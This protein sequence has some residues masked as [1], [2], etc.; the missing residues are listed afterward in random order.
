MTRRFARHFASAADPRN[1]QP[2]FGCGTDGPTTH[3]PQGR[4][5]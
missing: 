5:R 4:Q 2:A 3:S 1:P